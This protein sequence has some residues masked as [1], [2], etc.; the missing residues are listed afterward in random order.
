MMNRRQLFTG[1]G[2]AVVAAPLLAEAAAEGFSTSRMIYKCREMAYADGVRESIWGANRKFADALLPGL[3]AAF[4]NA[5]RLHDTEWEDLYG[6]PAQFDLF[7]DCPT[8]DEF[9]EVGFGS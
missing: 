3:R 9:I 7:D 1:L 6:R 4:D 5:Y 8:E 2:A